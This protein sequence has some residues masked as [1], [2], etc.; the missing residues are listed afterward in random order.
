MKGRGRLGGFILVLS[1][2]MVPRDAWSSQ[3]TVPAGAHRL[4]GVYEAEHLV[5]PLEGEKPL[6]SQ[7]LRVWREG[8]V[9][10]LALIRRFATGARSRE[11]AT[12]RMDGVLRPLAF[13]KKMVRDGSVQLEDVDFEAGVVSTTRGG[14][15]KKYQLDLPA[16]TYVGP[17]LAVVTAQIA[18]GAQGVGE[19]NTLALTPEPTVYRMRAQVVG[20][21]RVDLGRGEQAA[22]EVLLKADLGSVKNLLLGS[23]VPAHH[24]WFSREAAP[25]FLAFR[26]SLGYGGPEVRILRASPGPTENKFRASD[27]LW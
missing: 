8:K 27:S 18:A 9:L 24:F 19:F 11:E 25:E 2:F 7:R 5:L 15:T 1:L 26:G 20:Q 16:D 12:A 21:G 3:V 14:E 6:G 23:F 4:E 22:Y 17:L 10:H 13:H